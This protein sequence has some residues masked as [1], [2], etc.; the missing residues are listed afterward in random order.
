[1]ATSYHALVPILRSLPMTLDLS[2][3]QFGQ[4]TLGA[5]LTYSLLQTL[6][7]RDAFGEEMKLLA[8]KWLKDLNDL[9]N[10]VKGKQLKQ[11][12]WQAKVDELLGKVDL[13]DTLKFLD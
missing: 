2:R 5:L 6:V 3:R 7:A 9:S 11:T 4:Q 13:S 1:M 12:D 10:D 8:G